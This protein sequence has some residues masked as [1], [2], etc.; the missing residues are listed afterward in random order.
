M[1][2]ETTIATN[3][4]GHAGSADYT[5][6]DI[7]VMEGLEAVRKR[8]GMYIGTTGPEGVFHLVREIVDNSVDEA[9]AGFASTVDIR[10][11]ADGSVTVVDDGRGIP[12]DTHDKT[13]KSALETVMTTLH[14]GGKFGG[15]GYQVSG[16]LHGV[17]ASVV[18]ALSEWTDVE[19]RRDGNVY[20]QRF[21]RGVTMNDMD[22]RPQTSADLPG[23]G[24]K[25]T[26]MPDSQV[27][28]E[29]GYEWESISGRLR[30]M[31]YLTQGL[32]IRLR[33]DWHHETHWPHND[34]TFRFDGGVK[35]FVR[36]FNR[37]RGG[38]HDSVIYAAGTV[39]DVSVEVAFQYNQSFVE[40]CLSF[41]NVIRTGDGGTHVT[42]FRSALTRVLNDY[43]KKNNMLSG[44]KDGVATLSGEDVREG[45]MS[46]ISVKV[47][48]PQFEGQTKGRLGN[49][50]V[51]GTV[52][53]LVGRQ[54]SEFLEDHPDEARI[55]IDKASTAARAREAAK[56]ARDLIIRKNAMDGGS[57]PGKLADCTE[58]DP[59]RSELYIV[60]GESAG[61][62]AKQGRDRQFQ[63]ILPLK[64]KI[65]NVEKARPERMFAHEEIAALITAIGAG[66]GEEFDS[67]K[68]RYHR[69]IIMT[70]ADIDGAHIRTLLL[71]F[72][73]RNMRQ[74]I[75]EGFLYIAQPPLY[76]ASKGRRS[77]WLYADADLDNWM[78]ERVF[79]G[80]SIASD[81]EDASVEVR[82]K[83]LG[84]TITQLREFREAFEIVKVL[85]MPEEVFFDLLRDPELQNLTF[86]RDRSSEIIGDLD[87]DDEFE[88]DA[89]FQVSLFN[90]SVDEGQTP[91]TR[92]VNEEPAQEHDETPVTYRIRDYE[93]TEDV[94]NN[95][96][97]RRSK[98]LYQDVMNF[99]AADAFQL[100][101][102]ED[103]LIQ[104]LT[105]HE[106]P[107]ALEEN[108]DTS[109]INIQ[110]YKGL[111]EM[112]P[113]QLWDTTMNPQHRVMLQVTAEDAIS[114]DDI[115]RTL[116]GEEVAPRRDFIRANALEVKNL[117]V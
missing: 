80:L 70:D 66:M 113:D 62:S 16:G 59:S 51:K 35:S 40:N 94:F 78:A 11:H 14:A 7:T 106:L 48:D 20:S 55:I 72:F 53:Q 1:T 6:D 21:E 99:I 15:K 2:T 114:A 33:S 25:V 83:R 32:A 39:D 44:G 24:T 92:E 19:V 103:V 112:N 36:T 47:K 98:R 3:G 28:P 116:M 8:P 58:K 90:G 9:M 41:A 52:E 26:W 30:E 71:T 37:R 100:K 69:I 110:R 108:S 64:G 22:R 12:V 23:N 49:P 85:G 104:D 10:I 115:F 77:N 76:K 89:S 74:L 61:G 102:R 68:L 46:V 73:F 82:G 18:N 56:K 96:A 54:L 107:E 105:W 31:A 75:D 34:V 17:G 63:A 91:F 109:G 65:L 88:N 29:I 50:E 97:I 101:R 67:E 5:A 43:A 27:F 84:S 117:D 111:G 87:G 86:T 13:G 38:I 57:L 60:E 81:D 4:N 93:L 42:G 45:L 79:N 95:P